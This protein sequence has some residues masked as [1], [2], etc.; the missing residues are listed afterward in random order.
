MRSQRFVASSSTDAIAA[1]VAAGS[2]G[3]VADARRS[4]GGTTGATAR[5]TAPSILAPRDRPRSEL[6]AAT[7]HRE[8][9]TAD[10]ARRREGG[11]A[12]RVCRMRGRVGRCGGWRS[13]RLDLPGA[14]PGWLD[15]AAVAIAPVGAGRV[16]ELD[17]ASGRARLRGGDRPRRVRQL[18]AARDRARA[19]AVVVVAI[20]WPGWISGAPAELDACG[21]RDRGRPG[22]DVQAIWDAAHA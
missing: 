5:P 6:P 14:R 21:G 4:G 9:A 3:A 7:E 15:A 2:A 16:G 12:G 1:S 22:L 18:D 20:A 10:R 13:R 19:P 17:A 11:R 8:R